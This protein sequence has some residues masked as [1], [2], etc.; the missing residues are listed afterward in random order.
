MPKH[1]IEG[2]QSMPPVMSG[3]LAVV[4]LGAWKYNTVNP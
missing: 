1:R 4:A 2:K 3:G